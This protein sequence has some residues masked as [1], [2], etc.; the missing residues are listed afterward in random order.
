MNNRLVSIPV[1][2]ALLV[3]L[4]VPTNLAFI[5]ETYLPSFVPPAVVLGSVMVW[6]LVCKRLYCPGTSVHIPLRL[7]APYLGLTCLMLATLTFTTEFE[8]GLTKVIEFGTITMIAC[9]AP[10]FVLNN[11]R[12]VKSFLLMLI[13]VGA[14]MAVVLISFRLLVDSEALETPLGGNYL[15]VQHMS[16]MAGITILYY[17]FLKSRKLFTTMLWTGVLALIMAALLYSGGKGPVLAFMATT[18]IMGV[19]SVRPGRFLRLTVTNRRLLIYPFIVVVLGSVVLA[20]IL[21]TQEFNLFLARMDLLLTPGHYSQVERLDNAGVA[22]ELF[23]DHPLFGAGIGSFAGYAVEIDEAGEKMR[24]PHN[25]VLEVLAEM[26]IFGFLLFSSA[27]LPSFWR[28]LSLQKLYNEEHAPKVF[29]GLL[30][31]TLL[32]AMT[33][34]YIANPALFAFI[35]ASYGVE[36]SL[37][38]AGSVRA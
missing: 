31:Y 16:G 20:F 9:F 3:V 29:L 24:W 2:P 14:S 33:S 32:N 30:I 37:R 25:I 12:R 5:R 35:G 18:L 22:V 21:A 4:L 7:L 6:V 11:L 23:L 19:L 34:Q 1:L 17:F 38:K 27:L 36:Y 26:G 28:L 15:A 8:F 13:L 10:I